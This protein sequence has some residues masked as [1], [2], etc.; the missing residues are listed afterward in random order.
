M[1]PT[2]LTYDGRPCNFCGGTKRYVCNTKCVPCVAAKGKVRS[3]E[4]MEREGN[5]HAG[6][7]SGFIRFNSTAHLILMHLHAFGPASHDE[8]TQDLK[9]VIGISAN[10]SRLCEHGFVYKVG[11]AKT[12]KGNRSGVVFG[13][14]PSLLAVHRLK[15]TTADERVT[16]YRK[17]KKLRVS[18]VFEFRGSIPFKES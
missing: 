11:R 5:G 12:T 3:A 14:T 6:L 4:R 1:T 8:L 18:S 16:K 13:L 15:L 7:K 17:A 10:L 2:P 9:R